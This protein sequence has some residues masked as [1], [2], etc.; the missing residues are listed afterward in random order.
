[1]KTSKRLRTLLSGLIIILFTLPAVAQRKY[2]EGLDAYYSGKYD[3]AIAF[4][5][6]EVAKEK[7]NGDLASHSSFCWG[8]RITGI[9]N[10]LRQFST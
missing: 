6:K 4:F 9:N 5:K 3:E 2:K 10:I 1:M 8:F 7:D